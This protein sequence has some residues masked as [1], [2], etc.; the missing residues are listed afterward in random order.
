MPLRTVG[1]RFLRSARLQDTGRFA[2]GR[3]PCFVR[4]TR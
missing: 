4:K 1:F 2:R 3:K